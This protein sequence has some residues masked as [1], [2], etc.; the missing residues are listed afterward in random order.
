MSTFAFVKSIVLVAAAAA[1]P[2]V[3][4]A[5]CVLDSP[6]ERVALVELFTSEGCNSCPPADRW[7]RSLPSSTH[8]AR[9]VPLAFHVD[10]WNQL[11]WVDRFS[12]AAFSERQ[13]A[14][15]AREHSHVIYT[16][17][18]VLDGKDLRTW[19]D[20]DDFERRVAAVHRDASGAT[21]NA[22]AALVGMDLQLR[23][24]VKLQP[25]FKAAETWIA[26]YEN[27]LRT[28]VA[29]GENAGR[30]LEHD[31]VVRT[32]VGPLPAERDGMVSLQQVVV[33]GKDWG[34]PRLGIAVFAQDFQSGRILQAVAQEGCL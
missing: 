8:R 27:G 30:S 23:G 10:Y 11:G 17:Q 12:Q 3:T 31:F 7:L 19:H 32:I 9:V 18:V 16:P 5:E 28:R 4:Y 33:L 26:V 13:R 34:I 25:P 6:P 14:I 29:A 22:R 1:M 21:I 15:A 2:T 24:S 20:A